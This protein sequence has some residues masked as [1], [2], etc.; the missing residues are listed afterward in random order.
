[1]ASTCTARGSTRRSAS[2]TFPPS[3][4]LRALP[5]WTCLRATPTRASWSSPP[6]RGPTRTPSRKAS[7]GG[8]G[9]RIRT[10]N[11]KSPTSRRPQGHRPSY[12]AIIRINSQSGKG[13]VA[14]I[15]KES[16][17]YD[18]PKAMH[19]EVGM[20]IN[21][22][23]D[24][25]GTELSAEEIQALYEAEFLNV[26]AA[27]LAALLQRDTRPRQRR[28]HLALPRPLPGGEREIV[29]KGKGPI[30][31][32]VH[33]LATLGIAGVSVLSFHEDA[34]SSGSEPSRWPTCRRGD[35]ARASP[36]AQ[37]PIRASPPR[38]SA[39]SSRRSTGASPR[40]GAEAYTGRR[41][42]SSR[43]C[44]PTS[45]PGASKPG[46]L[47]RSS[48]QATPTWITLPS[49][50]PSWGACSRRRASASAIIARPDP[51][52]VAAFRLLGGRGLAFL[53]TAGALDSMV[54]SYTANRKPRSED[55]YAP[56]G[57]R[58]LPSRR[59]DHRRGRRRRARPGPIGRSSPIGEMP[60][61]LQGR[62]R[63]HRR[64]R[65]VAALPRALR[66][67]VRQGAALDTPRLEGR[68][69]RPRHGGAR[70]RRIMR[71]ARGRGSRPSTCAASPARMALVKP[72]ELAPGTFVDLPSYEE[73]ART[74]PLSSRLP[75]LRY[76]NADPHDAKSSSN[77]RGSRYV[78]PGAAAASRFPGP[79][80]TGFT[81]CPTSGPGIRCTKPSTGSPPSPK[82]SSPSYRAAAVSG[83]APSAPSPCIRERPFLREA[84]NPSSARRCS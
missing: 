19:P 40:A 74:R 37:G 49:A 27:P 42:P 50:P 32:F 15:L 78:V 1:M 28:D 39:P 26:V 7:S 53:V 56:G 38:A 59:R 72:P 8:R 17:G 80:S 12:E 41:C 65:G 67:L 55:D 5:G 64:S 2:P 21:R 6:S 33:S 76:A 29:G 54:S 20:F 62:T 68:S 83:G 84:G 22:V 43:P 13:G 60:R 57:S 61:G 24:G 35:P 70:L 75:A 34:L 46:D 30:D 45:R 14:Y 16:A 31:A 71:A 51:D 73:T 9:P 11:G 44:L 58:A 25:K 79:S 4:G 48:S 66:L 47:T 36:G 23:A 63:R 3:L 10:R 69:P 52:D 18:L 82:S 77:A 81:S